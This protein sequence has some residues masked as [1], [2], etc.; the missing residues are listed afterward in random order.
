[1][2]KCL[3]PITIVFLLAASVHGQEAKPKS[4]YKVPDINA[5]ATLLVKPEFDG[6]A[7]FDADGTTLVV[8]VAVDT[9]GN[10]ISAQCSATCPASL[11]AAAEHAALNSK[12]APLIVRGV[13][14]EYEE[15]LMYSVAYERMDWFNFGT[16]I[17]STHI[18][19]NITLA[20]MAAQ[21]TNRWA[22]EKA[23]LL[24][25]DREKDI[26]KRIAAIEQMIAHFKAQL[27]G[28]DNWLF[29]AGA[30]MRNV[31]FWLHTG[32]IEKDEL[33]AA[34]TRI[35]AVADAAPPEVPKEFVTVL[36]EISE[37]KVNT[38]L[39]DRELRQEIAKL[40]S[41]LRNYPR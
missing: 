2:K 19:D 39:T 38:E 27:K 14:I 16:A 24:A 8:K 18:F 7:A 41:K 9:E 21:L 1:M 37:H 22:D 20:P 26:N 10:A 28:K 17:E 31:T 11:K 33:Q 3:L 40:A 15:T 5:M 29:S 34:I 32:P 23:R 13:A 4:R 35:A 30:A 12:Y 36:K 25:I 6:V